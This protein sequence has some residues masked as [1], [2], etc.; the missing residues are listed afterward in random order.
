MDTLIETFGPEPVG[1]CRALQE[2]GYDA[3]IVGG[4]VRDTL[5][6][7]PANDVDIASSATPDEVVALFD[8]TFEV[9]TGKVH[10][11]I[12]VLGAS[13]EEYEVTTYRLDLE[14]DGRHATVRFT[15]RVEDDLLRRDFTINAIAV[16]P[17][18]D[19]SGEVID[20]FGGR[21]DLEA[22]VLRA[23][24]D[25][26]QRFREDWLRVLRGYRFAA[27]FGFGIEDETR[28]AMRAAV[29]G[30]ANCSIE[31]VRDE[32]LKM[33]AQSTDR[34]HVL[35][36]LLMMQED[37]VF[38][39]VMPEVEACVGVTQNRHH[40][41]DVFRHMAGAAAAAAEMSDDPRLFMAALLHD[42]GKPD[43]R[44]VDGEGAVH[45]YG[46]EAHGTE[47]H[48]IVGARIARTVMERLKMKNADM[49]WITEAVR[50]HM[51]LMAAED[52]VM[53]SDKAGRRVL[54]R[55][56]ADLRH[57]TILDLDDPAVPGLLALRIADKSA[58]GVAGKEVQ[59]AF[60]ERVT[61]LLL[62]MRQESRAFRVA[63]L[64]IS[65]HD[66]MGLGVQPGPELGRILKALLDDVLE[67]RCA[68]EY[69]ALI[70]RARARVEGLADRADATLAR[71]DRSRPRRPTR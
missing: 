45:F 10:G 27:R 31:R 19:G 44:W 15:D 25:P 12:G 28:A 67:E 24:G 42:V 69:D 4:P 16:R 53:T 54:G 36:A 46:N 30:L 26:A 35:R 1:I 64:A 47:D 62:Q 11:T 49:D 38:A 5:R 60:I 2:A 20:P 29:T 58:S 71:S 3:V 21:A 39:E 59:P 52:P 37:G 65:G 6:G 61:S 50:Q 57:V 68:N 43:S 22:G 8:R 33:G 66:L 34:R 14:T 56:M 63:D 7:A 40:G 70:G 13:G 32:F 18:P 17:L 9:G 23:V 51:R 55:I 48:E 41:Y